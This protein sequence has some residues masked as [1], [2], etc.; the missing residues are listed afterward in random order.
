[1][2]SSI[3]LKDFQIS[4]LLGPDHWTRSPSQSLIFNFEGLLDFKGND[5]IK[6][7][8][9]Y[10]LVASK[11]NEIVSLQYKT[12]EALAEAICTETLRLGFL[13]VILK[14]EKKGALLMADTAGILVVRG[15]DL[16]TIAEDCIFI[17][18]LALTSI[19]GIQG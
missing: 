6:N 3:L 2:T 10:S 9:S 13:K 16:A 15:G 8:V 7:T 12:L 11:I 4:A 5:N 17:K 14:V 1:M 18:N 19:I